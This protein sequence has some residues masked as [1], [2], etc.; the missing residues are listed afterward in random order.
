MPPTALSSRILSSLAF[1]LFSCAGAPARPTAAAVQIRPAAVPPSRVELASALEEPRLLGTL[2]DGR[3][4]VAVHGMRLAVARDGVEAAPDVIARG[5]VGAVVTEAGWRFVDQSG[6]RWQATSFLGPLER[7]GVGIEG[8]FR[9]THSAGIVAIL[10]G[11]TRDELHV[12][13][14]SAEPRL[15]LDLPVQGA[16]FL[17]AQ[18]GLAVVLGGLLARTADGGRTWERVAAPV[19]AHDVSHWGT[20]WRVS[21]PLDAEAGAEARRRA[22]DVFPDGRTAELEVE[23][24]ATPEWVGDM[25]E[26][27]VA[28]FRAAP[29]M[30]TSMSSLPFVGDA[31]VVGAGADFPDLLRFDGHGTLVERIARGARGRPVEAAGLPASSCSLRRWG[32]RVLATCGARGS[33]GGSGDDEHAN[34]YV[35]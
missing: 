18:N 22:L 10:R 21:L 20:H 19:A 16:S 12:T 17:D 8:S 9:P 25:L 15:A 3:H 11:E 1:A 30:L 6:A 14:G 28:L 34:L 13:D 33:D 23:P 4:A 7:A 26:L 5:I 35:S 27:F 24:L 32:A 29:A 2:P 31:F